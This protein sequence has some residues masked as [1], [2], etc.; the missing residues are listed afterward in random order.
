MAVTPS[1]KNLKVKDSWFLLVLLP[2]GAVLAYLDVLIGSDLI[3]VELVYWCAV[4]FLLGFCSYFQKKYPTI[5]TMG[6]H[7]IVGGFAFLLLGATIDILDDRPMMALLAQFGIEFDRQGALAFLEKIMGNTFGIALISYGFIRW[8]PWMVETQ[9]ALTQSTLQMSKVL[10]SLDDHIDAERLHISR[11]L[12][13]DVAQQ[14]THIHFQLQLCAKQLTNIQHV[15]TPDALAKQLKS[16]TQEVSDS[17]KS[18]RQI[19]RDLRP[20]TLYSIGFIPALEQHLDKLKS[21]YPEFRLLL[22]PPVGQWK[23]EDHFDERELLHLFRLIQEG[24]RNALKHSEGSE[25]IIRL[26]PAE[27]TLRI[28]VQDNGKGLPWERIPKEDWL[29]QH[30]HLGLVGLQERVQ[31]LNGALSIG[32]TT[33]LLSQDP[34]AQGVVLVFSLPIKNQ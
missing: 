6:W 25:I 33:S 28:E 30:G 18:V 32:S 27:N 15:V 3:L 17:L 34:V 13:D 8:V 10:M 24:T 20:E 26:K 5:K 11:E 4:V 2:L 12:H 14:L 29:I 19:S 1:F 7:Y 16:L 23:I 31:E 22:T 21:Q 9:M